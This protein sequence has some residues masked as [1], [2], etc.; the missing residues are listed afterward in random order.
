MINDKVMVFNYPALYDSANVSSGIFQ[1]RYFRLAI[2]EYVLL[3]CAAIVSMNFFDS[4][5]AYYL[6]AIFVLVLFS[7]LGF[8]AATKPEQGWYRS[9]ALAE[10]VKTMAWRYCMRS[11]P[12]RHDS[13]RANRDEFRRF[14]SDILNGG[15]LVGGELSPDF[16]TQD[17]ITRSMGDLRLESLKNRKNVYLHFRINEQRDWYKNRSIYN[18]KASRFWVFVCASVYCFALVLVLGRLTNT[19]W[20]F[21]PFEPLIV[22]AASIIGWMQIKKYNELAVSYT[23][24]AHEIGILAIRIDDVSDEGEFSEFINDAELAFSREHTQWVA[25]Q[26]AR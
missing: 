14:L 20:G 11:A 4:K 24:T 19:E 12:F 9:R 8:K 2:S 10:S 21:W 5:L 13:D 7:V 15:R 26:E 25:R 1:R 16:A 6:Y 17:Q 22:V 3:T 18:K 23:L